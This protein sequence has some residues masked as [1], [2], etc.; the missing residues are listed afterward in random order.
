MAVWATLLGASISVLLWCSLDANAAVISPAITLDLTPV[1]FNLSQL[2]VL[3]AL[4]DPDAL[5]IYST[6]PRMTYLP[7]SDCVHRFGSSCTGRD[8]AWKHVEFLNE[9]A[10]EYQSYAV[11]TN[12]HNKDYGNPAREIKISPP[13][14]K[15]YRTFLDKI[16]CRPDHLSSGSIVPLWGLA[17]PNPRPSSRSPRTLLQLFFCV[18]VYRTRHRPGLCLSSQ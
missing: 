9:R 6:N 3:S 10:G 2:E 12:E 15:S 1:S 8:Y 4:S 18:V 11:V 7:N 17:I 13:N 14:G 5:V 16:S